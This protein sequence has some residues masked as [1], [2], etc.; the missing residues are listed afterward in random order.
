[1]TF[2][3]MSI[4]FKIFKMIWS[5]TPELGDL[6]PYKGPKPARPVKGRGRRYL[7]NTTEAGQPVF[8]RELSTSLCWM[9]EWESVPN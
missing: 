6:M 8:C 4:H 9:V 5:S 3:V 1:M 7:E 2:D